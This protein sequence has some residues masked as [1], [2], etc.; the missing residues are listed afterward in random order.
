MV[1]GQAGIFVGAGATGFAI[2]DNIVKNISGGTG[3]QDWGINFLGA[4]TG[5]VTGNV[6]APNAAGPINFGGAFA[7]VCTDNEGVDDVIGGP[8]ASAT[9][10]AAPANPIFKVTGT[11]TITTITG[12]W[13][14]RRI[15]LLKED[16]GSLTVGGGGNIP[17]THTMAQ[18]SALDLSW[19]G[20]NWI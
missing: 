10:I 4:A 5:I 7:G 2:N 19:D 12:G 1:G 18:N 3:A 13:T 16:S 6:L 9:S 15:R 14:G 20:S 8:I 17:G 11:T